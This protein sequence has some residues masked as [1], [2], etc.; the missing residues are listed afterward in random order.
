MGRP[1]M[2]VVLLVIAAML[3]VAFVSGN[4]GAFIAEAQARI[5][6]PG[7]TRPIPFPKIAG[8]GGRRYAN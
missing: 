6:R 7:E 1:F 8:V 5:L 4:L 2:G 3:A